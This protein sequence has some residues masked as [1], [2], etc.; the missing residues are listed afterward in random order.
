LADWLY[1]VLEGEHDRRRL[2][3]FVPTLFGINDFTDKA[4]G[5]ALHAAVV[6]FDAQVSQTAGD[7]TRDVVR[8]V[9]AHCSARLTTRHIAVS[10]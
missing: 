6:L 3:D 8:L 7:F 1:C 5:E 10:N 9:A 2:G 4:A